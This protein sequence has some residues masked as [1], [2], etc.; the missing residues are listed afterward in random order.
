MDEIQ[1]L[2]QDVSP[3]PEESVATPVP[4]KTRQAYS[5]V[6]RELDEGELQNPAV[7]RLL[8][9]E[10][11]RL[12]EEVDELRHLRR[13]F[14]VCDKERAVLKAA[15]KQHIAVQIIK[16]VCFVTGGVLAGIGPSLWQS[17]PYGLTIL[18]VAFALIVCGTVCR[19]IEK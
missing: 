15:R 12:E 2:D 13:D 5:K 7:Q 4:R 16:D 18:L 17:P 1:K 3:R 14:S 11:D 6:R 10:L 9:N 8:V 19:I